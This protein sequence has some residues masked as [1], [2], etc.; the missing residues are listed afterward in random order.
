[1]LGR[2]LREGRAASALLFSSTRRLATVFL[3]WSCVYLAWDSARAIVRAGRGAGQ[4]TVS[5]AF[6]GP[7]AYARVLASDPANGLLPGARW[8]LWFLPALWVAVAVICAGEALRSRG[9]LGACAGALYAV[10]LAA[11]SYAPLSGVHVPVNTRNG[12]FFSL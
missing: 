12:P 1:F 9:L 2:R 11:G 5:A 6:E 10:G 7:V 4:V 8:H 3:V